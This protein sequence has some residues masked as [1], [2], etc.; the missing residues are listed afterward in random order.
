[1][2][3]NPRPQWRSWERLC[4]A[5]QNATFN[6]CL[7]TILVDLSQEERRIILIESEVVTHACRCNCPFRVTASIDVSLPGDYRIEIYALQ[8]LIW[9]GEVTVTGP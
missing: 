1:M 7:D 2:R 9:T 5:P 4:A 3:R 6:C 8:S